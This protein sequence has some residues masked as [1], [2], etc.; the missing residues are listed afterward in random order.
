MHCTL[1]FA[2]AMQLGISCGFNCNQQQNFRMQLSSTS[3]KM[4]FIFFLDRFQL[5]DYVVLLIWLMATYFFSHI[6]DDKLWICRFTGNLSSAHAR[7]A[8]GNDL[9]RMR[10]QCHSRFFELSRNNYCRKGK[11]YLDM[12]YYV[13]EIQ[14]SDNEHGCLFKISRKD[15]RSLIKCECLV[16]QTLE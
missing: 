4:F 12:C 2:L 11:S 14:I 1:P 16:Y 6:S 9:L 8:I 15:P 13:S 5:S 10:G 7:W 3:N